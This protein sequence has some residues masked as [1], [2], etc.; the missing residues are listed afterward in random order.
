[1]IIKRMIEIESKVCDSCNSIWEKNTILP[2]CF[3]CGKDLCFIC[4]ET[5]GNISLCSEHNKWVW[6][7]IKD[8]KKELQPPN[9]IQD[10][11]A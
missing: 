3:I 10:E 5:M 1:M 8:K 2:N 11:Q 4:K 9:E 6:S 7:Q